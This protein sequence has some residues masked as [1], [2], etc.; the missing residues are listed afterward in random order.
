M[1]KHLLHGVFNE[2]SLVILY[3]SNSNPV[4]DQVLQTLVPQH[5]QKN[6]LLSNFTATMLVSV[7]VSFHW[8][9]YSNLQTCLPAS[10]INTQHSNWHYLFKFKPHLDQFSVYNLIHFHCNK[11]DCKLLVLF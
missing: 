3:S 6:L 10:F 11:N 8:N 4:C 9:D 7:T 5:I 2:C 1:I